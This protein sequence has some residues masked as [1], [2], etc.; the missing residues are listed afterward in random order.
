MNTI[1]IIAQI[2]GYIGTA[3]LAMSLVVSN[4]LRFRWLNTFGCLIF[5]IYGILINAFPVVLTNGLLLAI[6]GFYLYKI[7]QKHEIFDI[8][9]FDGE[10]LL[11]KKFLQFYQQDILDHFPQFSSENTNGQIKFV[12]LRDLVIAN[13]F[14]AS[15][16]EEGNALVKINYTVPKYRDFKIGKYIFDEE[17]KI[18]MTKG[19]KTILYK[20]L[21]HKGHINFL[22]K[23]NFT[24]QEQNNSFSKKL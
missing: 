6:N 3:L 24:S 16:D 18:L 4:E 22:R 2:L 1:L 9:T 19:A 10:E 11:I 23:M 17:K 15:L 21:T 5:I 8:I 20:N 13:I 7:Y 14:I 12:V